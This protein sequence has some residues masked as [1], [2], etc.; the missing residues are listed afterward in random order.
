MRARRK[1]GLKEGSR[2]AHCIGACNMSM[3]AAGGLL[4][5]HEGLMS[6]SARGLLEKSM[7]SQGALNEPSRKSKE[8]SLRA[9]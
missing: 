4:H 6:V 5:F 1:S 8:G 9:P 3:R 2:R 7:S